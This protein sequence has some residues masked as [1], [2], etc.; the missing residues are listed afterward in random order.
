MKNRRFPKKNKNKNKTEIKR[1]LITQN[2]YYE[3][4]TFEEE[5]AERWL[6]SDIKKSLKFY[7]EAFNLYELGLKNLNESN[8]K[9]I[10]NLL[11]NKSRLLLQIYTDYL[12]NDGYINILKYIKL[13]D[14]NNIN[15]ILKNLPEI[16]NILENVYNQFAN[17]NLIDIWDLQ[18]NLLT[19]YLSLLETNEFY[20]ISSG[21]IIQISNKF[22]ELSQLLIKRQINELEN[23]SNFSINEK[24]DSNLIQ[25]KLDEDSNSVNL[26]KDGSGI[27]INRINNNSQREEI[28]EVS[29]QITIET[30]SEVILN[31][32]KF[33]EI[34][35]EIIIQNKLVLNIDISENEKLNDVQIN[36]L[37]DLIDKLYLQLEDIERTEFNELNLNLTEI[38]LIKFSIEG[39]KKI[40]QGDLKEF[41][42]F[43]EIKII[44]SNLEN[45]LSYQM[46]KIDTL[47]LS[48]ECFTNQD[49]II[50]WEL[51]SLLSK[52][53]TEVIKILSTKRNN[54]L[55][56]NI[57]D[58]LQMDQLSE[59]V[60]KL[61]TIYITNS[62]NEL[63]R[64]SIKMIDNNN[65]N[66]NN[67]KDETSMKV[68]LILMKNAKTLLLNAQKIS[69][70][71]CGM[72]ETIV[73]K[74]KRNYIYNQATSRLQL[75]EYYEN[76]NAMIES[77]TASQQPNIESLDMEIQD[78]LKDHPFY[79]RLL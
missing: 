2:D 15:I 45:L 78:L 30:L 4:G 11:Y 13:D 24:E 56:N 54:I 53:L 5:Q 44:E 42:K 51:S 31:C 17:N 29:D 71:S 64:Y 50:E 38:K 66:N 20:K 10:Y 28:M 16:V 58:Q 40:L 26:N 73:D 18:Y 68:S 27:V 57:Y 39:D 6:L 3:Q 72:Q 67:N 12:S 1:E 55:T 62:D 46:I 9:I 43:Q 22:I 59:I 34:I 48:I 52:K 70:Q 32:Y 79:S 60:F 76:Q 69:K 65:N 35:I 19:S 74:L 21:E 8:D 36:Y 33:I 77:T 61:C 75:M 47:E 25:D 49:S 23:W 63:R 14:I 41:L 37:I 7:L